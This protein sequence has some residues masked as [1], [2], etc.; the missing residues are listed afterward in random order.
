MN[1]ILNNNNYKNFVIEIKQRI[2]KAQYEALKNVNKELVE[3][4]W[5]I[6][7]SIVQHQEKY[8]WGRAVVENLSNELKEEFPK[9]KGFSSRNLWNMRNFYVTYKN[10]GVF[11]NS[12]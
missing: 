6:G 2:R 12:T 10:R 11:A 9:N 8:G 1:N 4:Y 5:D 3:L 7:K